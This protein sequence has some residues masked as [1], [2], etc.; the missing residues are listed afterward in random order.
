MIFPEQMRVKLTST[1]PLA[2]GLLLLSPALCPMSHAFPFFH[3]KPAQ[4]HTQDA[5]TPAAVPSPDA[6]DIK[7]A[8][9]FGTQRSTIRPGETLIPATPFSGRMPDSFPGSSSESGQNAQI[10]SQPA[11]SAPAAGAPIIHHP[12]AVPERPP[13]PPP[14]V[15]QAPVMVLNHDPTPSLSWRAVAYKLWI[16][17]EALP[18]KRSKSQSSFPFSTALTMKALMKAL[19]EAGWVTSH[20]SPSAGHLLAVKADGDTN[21]LRLI[22]AAHPGD[23]GNTVVR[24]TTDPEAKNFDKN[25]LESIF[26]RAQDIAARNELL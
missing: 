21:K 1:L 9:S 8:P 25:Q 14:P 5:V 12:P 4:E 22:F 18:P 26:S 24:A 6:N 10:N 19:R 16:T 11:S 13:I 2:C 20:F 7:T 15:V 23:G 3:R 17:P